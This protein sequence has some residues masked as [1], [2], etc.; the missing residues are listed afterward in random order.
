[1]PLPPT[2]F[3]I[4]SFITGVEQFDYDV[5]WCSFLHSYFYGFIELLGFVGCSFLQVLKNL[6]R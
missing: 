2:T 6:G 5:P 3:F 4:F 1:M